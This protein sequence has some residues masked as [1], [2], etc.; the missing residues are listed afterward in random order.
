MDILLIIAVILVLFFGVSYYAYYTAFRVTRERVGEVHT[1][2]R[3]R[4]YNPYR[5]SAAKWIDEVLETPYEEVSI[6]SFDGL[7][8]VGKLYYAGEGAPIQLMMHGYM[9]VAERDF[10]G[11]FLMA[12]ESGYSVL[13]IDERAHGKSGGKALSMGVNERVDCQYW[14]RYLAERFPGCQIILTGMSMG[15]ATVLM[16]SEL[17]LPENVKGIIADCGYMSP[18][19]ALRTKMKADKMPDAIMFFFARM[20]GLIFGHFDLRACTVPDAVKHAKV[21]VL[22]IHGEADKLV[23]AE[24][25]RINYA[26]CASEKELLIFPDAG[27]GLSFMLDRERYTS[28]VRAF[29]KN[30]TGFGT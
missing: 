24:M 26:A 2:M 23:P 16:A 4:Q 18:E 3:G 12:R 27:H 25:S 8:L 15:A 17:D 20:G 6:T 14:V 29:I 1:L 5:E 9:S 19:Q 21:P 22:F 30:T 7:R 10:S 13:L 11:G 28:A